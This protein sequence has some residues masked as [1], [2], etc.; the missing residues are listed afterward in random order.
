MKRMPSR[1]T[2]SDTINIKKENVLVIDGNALYKTGYHGAKNEYN[3]AGR[4]IGGIYQFLTML[5]KFLNEEMY[6]KVYVFWDGPYS[7]KLRYEI[8]EDYKKAR[9]KDYVN[10]TRPVDDEEQILE[11]IIVQNYLEELH[12]R[13]LEHPIVESDDFIAYYCKHRQDVDNITI[14]TNDRDLCQLIGENVKI[15]LCDKKCYVTNKNYNMHF[16]HHQKNSVL[17][18]VISGDASDSIKGVKGV[19][20]PTLLKHFP[21]IMEREVTLDEIITKSTL[22]QEERIK[23][24]KKPL[25]ALS[26]IINGTTDG[27]QLGRLYEVNQNLVDLSN[28]LLT[29][30]AEEAIKDLIEGDLSLDDRSIKNVMLLMKKDGIDKLIN[31]HTTEYFTPFKKLIERERK[32]YK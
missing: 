27:V 3:S 9:G 32:S 18:K 7:G 13:Q 21:E 14:V 19:K 31:N 5:R 12:V 16:S 20:E 1:K 29:E 28:P 24:K 6:H 4:H 10:G 17:V 23:N 2:G 8:Y 26:N 30:D 22:L 11:R 25:K 15:Y